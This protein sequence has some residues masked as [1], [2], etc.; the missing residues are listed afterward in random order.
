MAKP[1]TGG[2]KKCPVRKRNNPMT[3]EGKK[4]KRGGAR[5]AVSGADECAMAGEGAVTDALKTAGKLAVKGVK[6]GIKHRKAIGEAV[7]TASEVAGALGVKH[8]G[9]KTAGDIGKFLK[10]TGATSRATRGNNAT[11]RGTGELANPTRMKELSAG[12][13][14][15]SASG[16]Q[17]RLYF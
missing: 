14:S 15:N 11:R 16:T 13:V 7:A 17:A 10:G 6:L 1:K 2:C 9:L 3:G 5:V 8:K 4:K 12:L